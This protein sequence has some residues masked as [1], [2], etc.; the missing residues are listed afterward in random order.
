MSKRDSDKKKR[1]MVTA[2]EW[3]RSHET[4]GSTTL[5]LPRNASL[6]TIKEKC[7]R[8]WDFLPYVV[9]ANNPRVRSHDL[10]V[11]DLDWAC[12][13]GVHG[14]VG[15]SE[16]KYVCPASLDP[17]KPCPICKYRSRK[18]REGVDFKELKSFRPSEREIYNVIDLDDAKKGVQIFDYSAFMF[19]EKLQTK[20]SVS[21]PAKGYARFASLEDGFTMIAAFDKSPKGD[22]YPCVDIDF[23]PRQQPYD[24]DEILA[25]TYCLDD[26]PRVLPYEEL[27][28]I[29]EQEP[30]SEGIKEP[31]SGPGKAKENGA[32]EDEEV[33]DLPS[34][35]KG[36]RVEYMGHP[37]EVVAVDREGRLRLADPDDELI[38]G[39]D[40]EDVSP[41]S[42]ALA[43]A[44]AK[45]MSKLGP[46]RRDEEEDLP[47][48][49]EDDDDDDGFGKDD[50]EDEAPP[51]KPGRR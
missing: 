10:D 6:I 25:L 23:E 35:K 47:S 14:N 19:G 3:I 41:A 50:D 37:C 5:A 38:D 13:Y 45:G 12:A 8:R 2:Q 22:W 42:K 30:D 17:S 18:I 51:R 26:I 31:K 36:D 24:E 15:A 34:Y 4:K 39:V 49:Q 48:G 16:R 40:P 44:P 28:K 7:V 9:K 11:G 20:L 32:E 33:G 27:R 46:A 21:P 1:R 43:K 29:F